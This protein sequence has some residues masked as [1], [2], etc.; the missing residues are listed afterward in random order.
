[1]E[2]SLIYDSMQYETMKSNQIDFTFESKNFFSILLIK[3]LSTAS[4]FIM[5]RVCWII[6]IIRNIFLLNR[7]II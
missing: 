7:S 6:N 3:S 5:D 1:M 4:G 2:K